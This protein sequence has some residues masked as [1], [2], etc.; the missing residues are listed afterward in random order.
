[1][2]CLVNEETEVFMVTEPE[3]VPITGIIIGHSVHFGVDPIIQ[4]SV[5]SIGAGILR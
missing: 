3:V 5:P 1:M 2:L 4:G